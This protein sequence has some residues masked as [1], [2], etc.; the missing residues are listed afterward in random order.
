MQTFWF[1]DK[2]NNNVVNL[3]EIIKHTFYVWMKKVH[4]GFKSLEVTV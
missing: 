2:Y 4:Y 3:N 1:V